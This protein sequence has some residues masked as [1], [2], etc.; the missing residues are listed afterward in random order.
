MT[1]L[2]VKQA[3]AILEISPRTVRRYIDQNL[4]PGAYRLN[5]IGSR[6]DWRIPREDLD[7][8]LKLRIRENSSPT[9]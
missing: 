4:F 3:A 1:V 8:F 7:S 6:S 5:P 9:T 2:S